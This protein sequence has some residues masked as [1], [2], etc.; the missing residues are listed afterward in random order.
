M[1]S[2][3]KTKTDIV[4]VS[5]KT[6]GRFPGPKAPLEMTGIV[7]S[8]WNSKN[9]Y[10]T[11]KLSILSSDGEIYFT[12]ATCVEH[13]G[14]IKDTQ[15][16]DLLEAYRKYVDEVF[17]PIFCIKTSE[18]YVDK[19]GNNYWFYGKHVGKKERKSFNF[20]SIHP[21][22][23]KYIIDNPGESVYSI[24]VEPWLIEKSR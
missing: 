13:V 16:S 15:W 14:S 6:R 10:S 12:T 1:Y 21:D 22:D 17:V 7:W 9:Q 24:R 19:T 5:R 4:R 23:A 8:K 11:P 2:E 3:L 20:S 18:L